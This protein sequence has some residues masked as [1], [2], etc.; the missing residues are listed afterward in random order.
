MEKAIE[1]QK[2]AEQDAAQLDLQKALVKQKEAEVALLKTENE[3]LK[4][5]HEQTLASNSSSP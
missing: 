2:K 1:E 4:Q 5:Q 3:V